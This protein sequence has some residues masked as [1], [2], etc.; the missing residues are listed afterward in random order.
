MAAHKEFSIATD[1]KVHFC[2]PKSPWQRGT[3]ENTNRLL[4]QYFLKGTYLSVC[5]QSDLN[6]TARQ[7]NQRPR[8]TP[9][10]RNPAEILNESVALTD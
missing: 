4:R 3:N 8:K 9:D 7:L 2:D 1:V 6:R 5:S 10:F